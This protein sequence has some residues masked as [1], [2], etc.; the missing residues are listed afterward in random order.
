MQLAVFDLGRRPVLRIGD[1][2]VFLAFDELGR[3]DAG[4]TFLECIEKTFI[5]FIH[6][7]RYIL[8]DLTVDFG[9]RG[10]MADVLDDVGVLVGLREIVEIF[11]YPLLFEEFV[12]RPIFYP[13]GNQDV[14]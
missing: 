8:P 3:V 13:V 12:S 4:P 10:V 9:Q 1:T 5:A 7:Y 11:R 2:A 14:A 6:P